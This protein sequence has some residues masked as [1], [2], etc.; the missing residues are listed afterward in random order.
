[1]SQ[2]TALRIG[3]LNGAPLQVHY[4]YHQICTVDLP[5]PRSGQMNRQL[6]INPEQNLVVCW[7]VL[8]EVKDPSTAVSWAPVPM[9]Q[10]RAT[11]ALLSCGKAS[12]EVSQPLQHT[13]KQHLFECKWC[14]LLNCY[15]KHI[16][17]TYLTFS[18]TNQHF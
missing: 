6:T 15:F 4:Y 7:W 16:L 9:E 10:D 1:M 13:A 18:K 12:M 17:T 8:N 14:Q 11:L 2:N 3:I 5:G